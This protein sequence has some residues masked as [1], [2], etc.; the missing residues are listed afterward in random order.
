M[1]NGAAPRYH[2]RAALAHD[3]IRKTWNGVGVQP[4]LFAKA[5]RV[6]D[7]EDG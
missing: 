3:E 4:L 6:I 2:L 1:G 7:R 5:S